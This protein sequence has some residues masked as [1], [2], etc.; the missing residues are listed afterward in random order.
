MALSDARPQ[1]L[2]ALPA[3]DGVRQGMAIAKWV[4]LLKEIAP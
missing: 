4:E 2:A 3:G 1:V